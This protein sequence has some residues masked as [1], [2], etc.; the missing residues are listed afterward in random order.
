MP[1][2]DGIRIL[3][4]TQYEAGPSATQA[5]A[6][7]GA[8]VVKIE[9]P[10]GGDPGRSL[11]VG[12]D[13]SAYFCNWNAN[14]RSVA[15][16]L[17]HKQ[18]REVLLR[19]LPHYDIFIE[20]YGPGIVE[21]FELEYEKLCEIHPPLIYVRIKGFGS[22][23][24]YAHYKAYDMVA[25]AASGAFSATGEI[26]GIPILPGPTIGDSGT[27]MQAGMAVLAAYIQ[28]LRTGRG[29]L[30]EL[31]MQEAVTYYMRT[32]IAFAG[33]WG[34]QAVP[35]LGNMMGGAP[36]GLYRCAGDGPNDYAYLITVTQRHWDSLCVAIE[37]PDL[38]VDE[39]FDTGEKRAANGA[40]LAEE[41]SRWTREYEKYDVMR[42]LGDAGVPC[43]AIIDTKD[44]YQ[45]PHLQ[46][47]DFIKSVEHRDLGETPLLGFPT[48]MSASE[49]PI[50][51]A[52]YLGEH[53]DEVLRAD[54]GLEDGE[55]EVLRQHG[56]LG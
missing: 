12:G 18:G 3:D 32:R 56:V 14:K 39:R 42:I 19:M 48:R 55:L 43:S 30:I 54:L 44:L 15:L 49:V 11:A 20:N 9:P 17:T 21:R 8:D 28:R 31:S 34:E 23:G 27:G 16:D 2:L 46:A 41:I 13:Y 29:Q 35:R 36:T 38:T 10:S 53:G 25:Q 22:D 40:A 5:L 1:A 4:M 51:R 24:P 50:V 33:N 47:R 26:G 37:R 45:D 6:W 52:P 7:L